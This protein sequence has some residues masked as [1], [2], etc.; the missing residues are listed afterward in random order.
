MPDISFTLRAGKLFIRRSMVSG[1]KTIEKELREAVY[2]HCDEFIEITEN[3]EF[4]KVYPAF[5]GEM[6]KTI[7]RPFPKIS[8]I[9]NC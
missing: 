7:P 1:I 9:L 6:L 8:N 2:E 4:K 5:E 3:P